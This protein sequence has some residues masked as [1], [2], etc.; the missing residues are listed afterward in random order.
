MLVECRVS[1]V[2]KCPIQA[3]RDHNGF[4]LLTSLLIS[5]NTQSQRRFNVSHDNRSASLE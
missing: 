2:S 5:F 3:V 1:M 4:S